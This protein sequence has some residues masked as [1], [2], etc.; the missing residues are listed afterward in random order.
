MLTLDDPLSP[1]FVYSMDFFLGFEP[2]VS[3]LICEKGMRL[4]YFESPY[5]LRSPIASTAAVDFEISKRNM[6]GKLQGKAVY[7]SMVVI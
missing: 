2:V 4:K 7:I 1:V 3:A 6:T 5:P